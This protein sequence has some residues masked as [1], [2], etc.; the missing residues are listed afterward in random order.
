MKQYDFIGIGDI[1]TDAFIKLK[2]AEV[3]DGADGNKKICMNFGDKIPYEDVFVVPAV[4]NSTNACV[5]ASRLGLKS[6]LITNVGKDYQGKEC[7]DVLKKEKVDTKFIKIYK[8]KKT[9]YHYVLLFGAER[10]I[11]IKHEDFPYI[12]P[13]IGEPKW[14]Y[15]S[16][17][18]ANSLDF[19]SEIEK[20]LDK[21]PNVKLAFQPGTYQMK[22]GAKAL[23]GI[24]KRA[25]IFTCNKEE[26][27]RVLETSESD[28]KKLLMG[29][30]NLGPKIVAITDGKEGAYLA[31]EDKY[32]FM[33]IY[34]DIAPPIN[35]TG[36]GDA[37][38]STFTIA[39][40]LGKTPKE[41]LMWGPINSMSVTQQIGAR[42]GLLSREKLEEFLKNAPADYKPREI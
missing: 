6:A 4:G 31:Y 23:A 18:G 21:H 36:A 20:Y 10:T 15:L 19:H 38:S 17:L 2:E 37:F 28:I 3:K 33:P 41:A 13:E 11:L 29:I 8:D 16:S 5:S 14:I 25:T 27:Q 40:M 9:N 34:P 32:Y 35:R 12:F 7:L 30:R 26:S 39:I 42:A 22:F 1:V 24:Y